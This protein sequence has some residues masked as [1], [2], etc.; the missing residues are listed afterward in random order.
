MTAVLTML[1]LAGL[2]VGCSNHEPQP[3]TLGPVTPTPS[4]SPAPTSAAPSPSASP[5]DP[6]AALKTTIIAS[7]KHFWQVTDQAYKTNNPD[8]VELAS[9]ASGPELIR[10]NDQTIINANHGWVLVGN[11]VVSAKVTALPSSTAASLHDCADATESYLVN[12][13]TRKP[14]DPLPSGSKVASNIAMVRE[15]GLWKVRS[16]SGVTSC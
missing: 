13:K 1:V 4:S 8:P 3:K 14:V 6:Q 11:T 12:A 15:G 9:V 16:I 7:Y 2:L 10:I 5:A